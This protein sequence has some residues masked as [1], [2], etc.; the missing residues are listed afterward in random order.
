MADNQQTGS[1][2]TGSQQAT[3]YTSAVSIIIDQLAK[4]VVTGAVSEQQIL[5]SLGQSIE[6]KGD[7]GNKP[8]DTIINTSYGGFSISN[9][10][11]DWYHENVD[12]NITKQ[13]IYSV[14]R[15][16][17]ASHLVTFGK[18][19]LTKHQLLRLVAAAQPY[20]EDQTYKLLAEK[21]AKD[22][23]ELKKQVNEWSSLSRTNNRLADNQSTSQQIPDKQIPD[24]PALIIVNL[25]TEQFLLPGSEA[26]A[27][28]LITEAA[29]KKLALYYLNRRHKWNYEIVTVNSLR[30]YAII[31]QGD[32]LGE[33]V[34]YAD[35]LQ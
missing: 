30:H 15:E 26:E 7:K 31:D 5:R 1:Q 19:M 22:E 28:E 24:H 25:H 4:L 14:S 34:F 32:D 9:D 21:L 3:K 13:A 18:A 2:Q 33:N 6:A 17:V 29:Y 20:L 23:T 35:D 11:I 10:F 16:T 8:V 12:T 27:S